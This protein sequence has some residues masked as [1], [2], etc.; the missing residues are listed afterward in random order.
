MKRLLDPKIGYK[1]CY[2]LVVAWDVRSITEIT[3]DS[4]RFELKSAAMRELS[5]SMCSVYSSYSTQTE[6]TIQ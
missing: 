3:S 5:R 6:K 1:L 4:Y 2:V